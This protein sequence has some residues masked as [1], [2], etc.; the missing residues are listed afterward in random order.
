MNT[1]EHRKKSEITKSRL[2]DATVELIA[3]EGLENFRTK[4][5]AQRTG[6]AEGNIYNYFTGKDELISSCFESID[7]ELDQRLMSSVES[8]NEMKTD[9]VGSLEKLWRAYFGYFIE[10][11][12]YTLF[13]HEF[14]YSKRYQSYLKRIRRAYN[15]NFLKY[16]NVAVEELNLRNESVVSVVWMHIVDSTLDFVSRLV[17]GDVENTP[18]TREWGFRLIFDGIYGVIRDAGIEVNR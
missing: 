15:G 9:L 6:M 1:Q 18:E 8:M 12:Q 7:R 4:H 5:L 16:I 13:Y 11:P 3:E 14:R 17:K 10:H 2:M